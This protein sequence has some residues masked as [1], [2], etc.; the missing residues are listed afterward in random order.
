[1][2]H[3]TQCGEG[4]SAATV[5]RKPLD[6]TDEVEAQNS[7][8][9]HIADRKI[10]G[11]QPIKQC[12]CHTCPGV[13]GC[14]QTPRAVA[15]GIAAQSR[16]FPDATRR[17][18]WNCCAR[19]SVSRRHAPWPLDTCRAGPSVSRRHVPWP[20]ESL[21]RALAPRCPRCRRCTGR[22]SAPCGPRCPT[23]RRCK[24]RHHA[25]QAP[26]DEVKAQ[27]LGLCKPQTKTVLKTRLRPAKT[28]LLHTRPGV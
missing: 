20:L 19:P 24:R 12:V 23:C 6:S 8:T 17:G 18:H 11:C 26:R 10:I 7:K 2:G 15:T 25:P 3:G 22:R 16:A 27:I 21:V 28:M 1:M 5:P 14:F 13:P 4:V 9:L